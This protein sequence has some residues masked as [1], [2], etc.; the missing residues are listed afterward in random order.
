MGKRITRKITVHLD[1]KTYQLLTTIAGKR[2]ESRSKVARRILSQNLEN[3][4]ALD[5]Q[6]VL[7]LAVRKAVAQELRQTENRL[8]NLVSKTAITSASTE[9]L[10]SRALV[11][12]KE[13]DVSGVRTACRKRGVAFVREPLERIMKAYE[14]EVES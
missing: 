4:V 3:Q 2:D 8:A 10:V 12:L 14:N 6:D 11:L 5:V 1:E 7:V 13:P 9:N